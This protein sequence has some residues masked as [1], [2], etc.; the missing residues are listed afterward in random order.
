[1]FRKAGLLNLISLLTPCLAFAMQS[2]AGGSIF[3]Q[4]EDGSVTEQEM[5]QSP[6]EKQDKTIKFER[7]TKSEALKK[8]PKWVAPDSFLGN[9]VITF[10]SAEGVPPYTIQEKRIAQ[11]NY[12]EFKQIRSISISDS[13]SLYTKT[14]PV[15]SIGPERGILPGEPITWRLVSTDKTKFKEIKFIPRPIVAK[16]PA[17]TTLLEAELQFA[18]P[19]TYKVLF[20]NID[21]EREF[22]C[23]SRSKDETLSQRC[24]GSFD[25]IVSPEVIGANEGICNVEIKFKDSGETYSIDL[26][27]GEALLPY[28]RGEK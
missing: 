11:E 6:E 18:R 24:K 17:G 15:G 3:I 12:G 1:M 9:W 21:R 22:Q 25:M 14:A 28:L 19:T 23:I 27:W 16:N 13:C 4:G 26:P 2:V 20:K 5:Y 7:F 10:E 8:F